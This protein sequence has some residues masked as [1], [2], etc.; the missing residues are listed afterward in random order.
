MTQLEVV[1][2]FA[3]AELARAPDADAVR[4]RHAEHYLA[5][6]E[7]LGP[8]VRV[9][10]RGPALDELERELGNLRAALDHWIADGDGERALR[11]AAAIEPYWTTT[12]HY[13]DG[14]EMIDAALAARSRARASERAAG[15]A[16]RARSS[17]AGSAWRR[18]SRTPTPRS[19]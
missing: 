5:L 19:R 18:A 11:L 13:R 4:R 9:T 3:A 16:S 10:G 17:C 14:A 1:R 2:Q 12:C 15:R 7:R 6:A 8:Q